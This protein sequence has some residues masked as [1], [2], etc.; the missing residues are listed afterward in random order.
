MICPFTPAEVLGQLTLEEKIALLAGSDLRRTAAVPRVSIPYIKLTDGPNG[1]RGG[2]DFNNSHPSA[3]FPSPSC[4]GATWDRSLAEDMGAGIAEDGI[5]KQCHVILGPTINIQR[6][7]RAGR[8]FESYSEDPCLTGELGASWIK[9]CQRKGTAATMKHFVGNESETDRRNVSSN[10]PLEALREVYLEPFR[11]IMK[12]LH[13]QKT[14]L[15]DPFNNQPACVM[16]AYNRL[17]GIS[18]SENEFTLQDILKKE[19]GF[20]GLIMSDWFA[21]HAHGIKATDLEMPGPTLYRKEADIKDVLAKGEISED[22]VDNR[23]IKVLELIEKVAPLGYRRS[24]SEEKEDS[25]DLVKVSQT[26]RR[27]GAEGAVLLKNDDE[28]LPVIPRRGLRIACI[29]RPWVQ[30]IQSGGGSANLTPQQVV[31]PLEAFTRALKEEDV[32]IDHHDGCDIHNFLPILAAKTVVEYFEGRTV[33]QGKLLGSRTLNQSEVGPSDEKPKGLQPNNFWIRARFEVT[34][35]HDGNHTFAPICLG[36]LVVTSDRGERWDYE[37]ESDLFEYF[38]NPVKLWKPLPIKMK[39][40]EKVAM[41]V[42][43]LPQ[44][45]DKSIEASLASG[46][47]VGFEYQ[48]DEEDEIRQATKAAKEADIVLV[49]TATGKDWESEG[50]DRHTIALP[51]KQNEL[52]DQIS[53]VQPNVVVLNITGSVVQMPWKNRVK[54]IVQCWFG[55]QEG[56]E[57]L[58]DVVLGR[59]RAPAS[60]K[61]ASTWPNRIEDHPSGNDAAYFP[62]I[63]KQDGLNVDYIESRLVGYKHYN[64]Q[65]RSV[66]PAFY[67]GQGMGGYTTFEARLDSIKGSCNSREEEY[68]I[69]VQVKNTGKRPGKFVIQIYVEPESKA[70]GRPVQRVSTNRRVGGGCSRRYEKA[71]RVA[72]GTARRIRDSTPGSRQGR[73]H[74]PEP[75]R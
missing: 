29:G 70:E 71:D 52:V 60:G 16:T 12:V 66:Q 18:S 3:L 67:F 72:V 34:S 45:L 37:G 58:V 14:S 6:D 41:V 56:G 50:F 49:M 54:G 74:R 20:K 27:I 19:W 11:R 21:L 64:T 13:M 25:V 8:Y 59:G 55:G 36:S 33:G 61:L 30:A 10:I 23:V 63:Q 42:D 62:G 73:E 17:N 46:F 53:K 47:K 24:P 39:Q 40:N 57:A 2:G 43:Y 9:G 5:K 48:K 31:Q 35:E 15:G 44:R 65:S 51:R 28:I 7:P 22:D 32:T 38:L 1:A 75:R 68:V 26:I 4:L 69:T